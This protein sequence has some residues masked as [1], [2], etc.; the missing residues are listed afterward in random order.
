MRPMLLSGIAAFLISS[1]ASAQTTG[2]VQPALD[3]TLKGHAILPAATFIDPPADA[4]AEV[5]VSGKFTVG[6]KRTDAIGSVPGKSGQSERLTG[7]SV[8]FTGQ[9]VQ[10]FSGIKSLGN[11]EFLVLTDNGFGSKLNSPDALLMVHRVK[12]DWASGKVERLSTTFLHDPDKKVPFRITFEATEK[13]YLTGADFDLE[14]IQPVGTNFWIGEEFGP[15]LLEVDASGKILSV[16][17]TMVDGKAAKSPDHFS[18]VAPAQPALNAEFTVR[19]SR[20]YEGMAASPDGK[21]LYPLLEGP[22]WNAEAKAY[23]NEGGKEYLRILEFS[24]EQKSWTGRSWRYPLEVNGHAIGDFNM[25]DAT[26]ALVIERDNGEGDP[27]MA[28]PKDVKKPDCFENAAKFKRVFKIE[29]TEANAGKDV[30]K[31]ASIDLMAISDPDKMAKQGGKD[32][33]LM[34]PFFTIEDVDVVDRAAGLIVVGNDNNLPFSAGRALD[35]AD[36]NEFLLIDAKALLDA[37]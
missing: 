37:Q 28:C 16:H 26:T 3:A 17:E 8:P 30:R 35:K 19:R 31:I 10:G 14:S 6:G 34:F 5:K 4:P 7:L 21:F 27:A 32:G 12:A 29:M 22:L 9:P 13:R 25:I 23:E 15:Y 11:G 1:A 2:S 18:I 33:K 36:D 20:G 24:T